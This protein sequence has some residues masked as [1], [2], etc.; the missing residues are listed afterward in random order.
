MASIVTIGGSPSA[1]SRTAALLTY[2][3][4]YLT[5][6]GV[7][8]SAIN[9]RDLDP[10]EVLRGQFNGATIQPALASVAAA[11]GVIVATPVYKASYTGV[12]KAF[13][14]LLPQ[15]GLSNKA[16]LPLA[17]GGTPAHSLMLDFALKPVLAALNADPVLTG[18]YLLDS[19]IEYQDGRD[20]RF[21]AP[22]AEARIHAAL[23]ALLRVLQ[24]S[25]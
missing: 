9:V 21:T 24:K 8:V 13:L 5:A 23:D 3:A 2:C 11:G 17:L 25:P 14:D 7:N 15:G 18:V 19:Q 20:L 4:D 16:A 1:P 6:G 10:A 22:E 12:L